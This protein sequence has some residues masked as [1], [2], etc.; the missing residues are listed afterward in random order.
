MAIVNCLHLPKTNTSIFVQ[1]KKFINLQDRE[2]RAKLSAP[3]REIAATR[4]SRGTTRPPGRERGRATR[5]PS[6]SPRTTSSSE[7]RSGYGKND[8]DL[9]QPPTKVAFFGRLRILMSMRQPKIGISSHLVHTDTH[10]DKWTHC[11][12][13]E[14]GDCPILVKMCEYLKISI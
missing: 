6:S 12:V 1:A 7:E 5:S 2:R 11:Y 13:Q 4:R 10:A 8:I 9:S 14:F 3:W